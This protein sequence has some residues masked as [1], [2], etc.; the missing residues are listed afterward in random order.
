M[1]EWTV[2]QRRE[3]F[4]FLYVSIVDGDGNE[5][6]INRKR[7]GKGST[8]DCVLKP[9]NHFSALDSIQSEWKSCKK[10]ERKLRDS[11]RYFMTENV[12][13]CDFDLKL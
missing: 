1:N 13:E 8:L 7:W 9:L 11:A 10:S 3:H 12:A 4:F 5:K 2:I 6:K